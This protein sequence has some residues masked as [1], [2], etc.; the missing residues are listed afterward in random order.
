MSLEELAQ[1]I[2]ERGFSRQAV[3]LRSRAGER[4]VEAL[5]QPQ[6]RSRV[7]EAL[8]RE[9][10]AQLE[11]YY[12]QLP[13]VRE[14]NLIFHGKLPELPA[15]QPREYTVPPLEI[16]VET[17]FDF[18][19][20]QKVAELTKQATELRV[21]AE[22]AVYG[23]VQERTKENDELLYEMYKDTD[24]TSGKLDGQRLQGLRQIYYRKLSMRTQRLKKLLELSAPSI[25]LA[26]E[27]IMLSEYIPSFEYAKEFSS[28]QEDSTTIADRFIERYCGKIVSENEEE[29]KLLHNKIQALAS[30]LVREGERLLQEAQSKDEQKRENVKNAF[31]QWLAREQQTQRQRVIKKARGDLP[32]LS[33]EFFDWEEFSKFHHLYP[34]SL[35]NIN[36]A[37]DDKNAIA[38]ES[39][40][41]SNPGELLR[42]LY[43]SSLPGRERF[44]TTTY[45]FEVQQLFDL[46]AG[47]QQ[48]MEGG[49]VTNQDA[50]PVSVLQNHYRFPNLQYSP[51]VMD[52]VREIVPK[53]KPLLAQLSDVDLSDLVTSTKM[54]KKKEHTY[55]VEELPKDPLDVT[56]G[57]DSGCC[58]FVPE[59]L[60]KL[61]NGVAVVEWLL[62][63]S[64]RLFGIYRQEGEK[65]QR[66]GLVAGFEAVH[67]ET[68]PKKEA[69][70]RERKRI[71]ACNSLELSRFGISGGNKT[72]QKL[73][74]YVENYLAGY[75][76]AFGYR[77]CAMGRH[78]YNTS[79]N[80]SGKAGDVVAGELE[81]FIDGLVRKPFYSDIFAWHPRESVMRSR[82]KSCYWLWRE[83]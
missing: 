61:Q 66:M 65:K 52:A 68:V 76:Q 26:N 17:L 43:K 55:V 47:L 49:P 48:L 46:L 5:M 53:L 14:L 78:N 60:E 40:Q 13:D 69:G 6:W 56:Y 80:F 20:L 37:L 67:R 29:Y 82:P 41:E 3:L 15:F 73:V 31:E 28:S 58:V 21:Q 12:Q 51:A 45:E 18:S 32:S 24:H 36:S 35:E 70:R 50:S 72:I 54:R 25:I 74:E 57:N 9:T 4:Y 8:G 22:A 71:L 1:A 34:F 77:G 16:K 42:H 62:N 44:L 23:E 59:E 64:I 33:G 27:I 83:K 19:V 30:P 2:E 75:A 10:Y 63:P 81:S 11:H 7:E 79:V 38:Y 39:D